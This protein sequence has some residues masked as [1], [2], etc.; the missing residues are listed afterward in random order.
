MNKNN[1]V[2]IDALKISSCACCEVTL[3]ETDDILIPSNGDDVNMICR[4]C[5]D[6]G[7]ASPNISYEQCFIINKIYCPTCDD[8]IIGYVPESHDYVSCPE[9]RN[10]VN[11]VSYVET[12]RKRKCSGKRI[13]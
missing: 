4:A 12:H 8:F 13:V 5:Y 3:L 6:L 1:K 2:D 10:Y 9:C 7:W 11:V